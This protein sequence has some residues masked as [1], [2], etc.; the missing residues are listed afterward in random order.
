[1]RISLAIS[2]FIGGVFARTPPGFSPSTNATLDVRY[3]SVKASEGAPVKIE[4]VTVSPAISFK[5]TSSHDS[6][7]VLLVDLDAPN[8]P[9]DNFY[10]PLL[11]WAKVIPSGS[12]GLSTNSSVMKDY[13]PYVGPAPPPGTGPHRYVALLFASGNSTFEIPPGF[14]DLDMSNFTNRV[15]F[16]IRKFITEGRLTLTGGDWFTCENETQTMVATNAAA[17]SLGASG[18][19][20]LVAF[21]LLRIAL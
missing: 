16:N 21:V 8:G 7:I 3:G 19:L 15:A 17:S 9:H 20:A 4:D 2:L 18:F 1:M 10:A 12:S 14:K 11:H 13:A 5:P 6:H